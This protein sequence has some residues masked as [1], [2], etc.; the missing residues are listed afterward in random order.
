MAR[1]L[2]GVMMR[3]FGARDHEV[4]VLGKEWLAPHFLRIRMV[5]PTVFDDAVAEPTSWLRFWFPD[6]EGSEMCIRDRLRLALLGRRVGR[7]PRGR[8]LTSVTSCPIH[9]T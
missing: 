9:E 8:M 2:Q 5:S 1:G 3:G 4:T 7:R 6:P